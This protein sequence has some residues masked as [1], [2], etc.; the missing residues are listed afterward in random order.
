MFSFK[1]CT[2]SSHLFLY[3]VESGK[4]VFHEISSLWVEFMEDL[5]DA[6]DRVTLRI[7]FVDHMDIEFANLAQVSHHH[8]LKSKRFCLSCLSVVADFFLEEEVD[9]K[10]FVN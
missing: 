3:K 10:L 6:A 4:I 2:Y 5:F 9:S 8:L 7:I 1:L